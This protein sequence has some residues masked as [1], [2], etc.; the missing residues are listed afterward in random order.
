MKLQAPLAIAVIA[1]AFNF[2]SLLAT[3]ATDGIDATVAQAVPGGNN[4]GGVNPSALTAS[5]TEDAFHGGGGFG[6]GGHPGPFP[7]HGPGPHPG[8]VPFPGPHPGPFPGPGHFNHDPFPV[9][10]GVFP[11]PHWGHPFF[12]RPIFGWN[13]PALRVVTCTA[14]DSQGDLFPVTEDGFIGEVYQE[15]LN[16][17][18]DA[19]IDRCYDETGG[20]NG[21]HLDGCTPGY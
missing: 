4:D 16:E 20:D 6:G 7:G 21:C 2:N 12:P 17:I 13:W 18:E 9:H 3:A 5:E 1:C 15:R 11:W 14:G 10:G 8:P 19:A